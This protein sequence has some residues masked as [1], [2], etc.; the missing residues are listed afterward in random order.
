MLLRI[1]KYSLS[2]FE[3]FISTELQFQP[4]SGEMMS[5]FVILTFL[6]SLSAFMP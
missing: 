2:A 1:M 5:Q 4:N 3:S 6:H